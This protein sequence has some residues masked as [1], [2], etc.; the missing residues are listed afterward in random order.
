MALLIVMAAVWLVLFVAGSASLREATSARWPYGLGTLAQA[1][2]REH[3][4]ATSPAAVQVQA[5]IDR[6]HLV[7]GVPR[8]AMESTSSFC[9]S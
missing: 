9:S 8:S 1:L 7:A 4:T 2:A 6:L 3:P 5:A